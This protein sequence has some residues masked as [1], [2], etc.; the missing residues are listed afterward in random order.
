MKSPPISYADNAGRALLH[1]AIFGWLRPQELALLQFGE[2]PYAVK[3][4]EALV[5]RLREDGLVLARKLPRHSGTAYVLSRRGADTVNR[6]PMGGSYRSGKDWGKTENGVWS[7]PASWQHD[8]MSI[9][10][11]AHLR[12]TGWGILPEIALRRGMQDVTKHPDGLAFHQGRGFWVEVEVARKTGQNLVSLVEALVLSARGKPVTNYSAASMQ[13]PPIS[14]A[15]VGIERGAR[16]ERGYSL[17]HWERLQAA[18]LRRGLKSPVQITVAWLTKR[19][20]G[21]GSI[22]LEVKTIHPNQVSRPNEK[23]SPPNALQSS[24][25]D[26]HTLARRT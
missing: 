23:A 19:G 14:G 9:G 18:I 2:A 8:L 22:E 16:D 15:I 26:R 25:N 3:Y 11:L 1:I 21:V 13:I 5:R 12:Q 20:A 24:Y 6:W 4:A 17:N 10:L 7:P